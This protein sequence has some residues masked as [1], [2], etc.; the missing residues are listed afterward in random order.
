MVSRFFSTRQT[1]DLTENETAAKI[2]KITK[3]QIHYLKM[4]PIRYNNLPKKFYKMEKI[5]SLRE[6]GRI[7]G[8]VFC[9]C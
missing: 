4:S 1:I 2:K 6:L 9:R 5:K 7:S 3:N 8:V